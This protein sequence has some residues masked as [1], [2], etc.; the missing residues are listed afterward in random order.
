MDA[1]F[2]KIKKSFDRG[3]V[4]SLA[5]LPLGG[6]RDVKGGDWGTGDSGLW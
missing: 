1:K 5:G 2:Q 3:E 4:E 6:M